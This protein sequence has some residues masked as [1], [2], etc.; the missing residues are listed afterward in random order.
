MR[1]YCYSAPGSVTQDVLNQVLDYLENDMKMQARIEKNFQDHGNVVSESP[2][3][4]P[5]IVPGAGKLE[6]EVIVNRYLHAD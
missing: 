1:I 6:D 4:G 3:Q 2:S 5:K